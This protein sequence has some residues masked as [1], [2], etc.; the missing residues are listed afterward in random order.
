MRRACPPILALVLVCAS[1]ALPGQA[2]AASSYQQVL[3]AY[4]QQGS[5][6]SCEFTGP[7]LANALKAVDTYGAQYFADF[8][9]AVQDALNARAGGVCGPGVHSSRTRGHGG[10]GIGI[11]AHLGSLTA[12]TGGSVPGPLLLLLIMTALAGLGTVAV[13]LYARRRRRAARA[14]R[15]GPSAASG[16]GDGRLLL[17]SD[18]DIDRAAVARRRRG[19]RAARGPREPDGS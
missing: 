9:Q 10:P 13:K 1:A 18:L 3:H 6:P 11:P 4:Q 17:G 5:V 12:P 8:T 15:R 2:R 7:Q 19:L 16:P 14:R